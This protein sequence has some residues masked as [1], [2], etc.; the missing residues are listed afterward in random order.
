MTVYGNLFG[1]GKFSD[2]HYAGFSSIFNDTQRGYMNTHHQLDDGNYSVDANDLMVCI[3]ISKKCLENYFQIQNNT[4]IDGHHSCKK[5]QNTFE[6]VSKTMP[7]KVF[8]RL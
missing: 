4:L 7:Q 3:T 8:K 2:F 6:L 5:N 1:I